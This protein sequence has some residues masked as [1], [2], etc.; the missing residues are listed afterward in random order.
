MVQ[1][2]KIDMDSKTVVIFGAAA[3]KAC[4]GPLTNEIISRGKIINFKSDTKLN[5]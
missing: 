5:Y 2:L 4:G 1:F 3:T